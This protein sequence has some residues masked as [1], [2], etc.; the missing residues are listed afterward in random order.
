MPKIT[1][2]TVCYNA[3]NSIEKTIISI[4]SQTYKN[5]EYIIID[6]GSTD[7]T[8]DVIK[9]YEKQIS[10]WK[11]EPDK[12]VYDAMN[13][14]IE[15]ATGEWVNFMN[16]GDSFYNT[17]VLQSLNLYFS[18]SQTDIIYGDTCIEINNKNKYRVI[19]EN[20]SNIELHLPFCH[21]SCFVKSSIIK[22]NL[23]LLQYKYVAD[24]AMFYKF[25]Q[26]GYKFKYINHIISN[27]QINEGLTASNM[28]KC[29]LET[30]TVNKRKP[31]INK[32]RVKMNSILI[33]ILPNK[34]IN[35][36]RINGYNKNPRFSKI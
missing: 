4:L 25:Y 22:N 13:K 11:S 12:G 24:Y 36:I 8:I 10:Y 30:F 18:D 31:A 26:L 3:I 19:P 9:K 27:Y 35:K 5:L 29:Y 17:E 28:Y 1:I 15:L 23:F 20:I 21:Q 32:W 16:A 34:L 7:G 33:T 6:G 2:I 14:G